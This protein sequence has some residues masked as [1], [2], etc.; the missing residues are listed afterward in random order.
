[1]SGFMKTVLM[2]LSGFNLFII[3]I[4]VIVGDFLS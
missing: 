3:T 1:M 2:K 4:S